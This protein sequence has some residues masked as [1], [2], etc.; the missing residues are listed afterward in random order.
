MSSC[1]SE[2]SQS[3]LAVEM[4]SCDSDSVR[5]PVWQQQLA[6]V[7]SGICRTGKQGDER[8]NVYED[9]VNNAFRYHIIL[10]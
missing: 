3:R 6:K 5:H 9:T 7:M 4:D 10:Y 1:G 2:N 8:K